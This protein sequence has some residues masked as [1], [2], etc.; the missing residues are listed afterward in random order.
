MLKA[1]TTRSPRPSGSGPKLPPTSPTHETDHV[2]LVGPASALVLA[3]TLP[4]AAALALIRPWT[5][6]GRCRPGSRG[7]RA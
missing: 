2:M 7:P 6:P 1:E 5:E 3:L 4:A